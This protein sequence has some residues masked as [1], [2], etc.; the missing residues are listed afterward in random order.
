MLRQ[1]QRRVVHTVGVLWQRCELRRIANLPLARC[2]WRKRAVRA[3]VVLVW[4]EPAIARKVPDPLPCIVLALYRDL[5][6]EPAICRVVADADVAE[7][8][9]I[10]DSQFKRIDGA[11]LELVVRCRVVVL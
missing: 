7:R 6:Q 5:P 4:I 1:A 9:N 10:W 2:L 11:V 3:Q 8:P